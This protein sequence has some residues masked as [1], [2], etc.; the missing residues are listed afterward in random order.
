MAHNNLTVTNPNPTPPTNFVNTG[1]TPPN[2]ATFDPLC[3]EDFR[4]DSDFDTNPPPYYRRRHRRILAAFAA[5]KAALAVGGTSVDHEG[6]GT[7]VVVTITTPNPNAPLIMASCLGNYTT[8]PNASRLVPVQ[9]GNADHHQRLGGR[10]QRRRNH[11]PD[12]DRH[13]LQPLQRGLHLGRGAE[14]QLRQR[15]V[16]DGGDSAEENQRRH[17]TRYGGYQW[18]RPD[19]VNQL[20]IH[21]SKEQDQQTNV[22]RENDPPETKAQERARKGIVDGNPLGEDEDTADIKALK[23]QSEQMTAQPPREAFKDQ[24]NDPQ[25]AFEHEIPKDIHAGDDKLPES[26]QRTARLGRDPAGIQ[27]SH[28]EGRAGS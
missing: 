26:D 28:Q 19:S 23:K 8:T 7:E 22:E 10:R 6:L 12:G 4:P 14:H 16:A 5:K 27:G 1:A 11:E 24:G 3:Y 15:N 25:Y 18:R 9:C 20:D 13:Q 17:L 21:M 2:P